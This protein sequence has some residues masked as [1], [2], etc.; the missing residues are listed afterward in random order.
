MFYPSTRGVLHHNIPGHW[1]NSPVMIEDFPTALSYCRSIG[2]SDLTNAENVRKAFISA[3]KTE[4]KV[5]YFALWLYLDVC[6]DTFG[7]DYF[8]PG[9]ARGWTH[10]VGKFLKEGMDEETLKLLP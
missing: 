2:I 4:Q 9:H 10:G 7:L 8:S 6:S 1:R 5:L 3:F